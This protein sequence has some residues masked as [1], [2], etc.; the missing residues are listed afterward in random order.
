[1]HSLA[2]SCLGNATQCFSV[3][4]NPPLQLPSFEIHLFSHLTW[5]PEPWC[6]T[7]TAISPGSLQIVCTFL[8]FNI[9]FSKCIT[10]KMDVKPERHKPNLQISYLN[11]NVSTNSV[12]LLTYAHV[13]AIFRPYL[14]FHVLIWENNCSIW[15]G[16]LR[17]YLTQEAAAPPTQALLSLLKVPLSLP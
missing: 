11:G 3:C 12:F 6:D 5:I 16:N 4:A 14:K 10:W 9:P 1:M 2:C 7:T 15:F 17:I 13:S 8:T